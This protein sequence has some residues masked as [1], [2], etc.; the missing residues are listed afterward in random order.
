MPTASPYLTMILALLLLKNRFTLYNTNASLPCITP[1]TEIIGRIWISLR[2]H[3]R[4]SS[5]QLLE[6]CN[7]HMSIN[8]RQGAAS[9][10]L[11]D[12]LQQLP[13]QEFFAAAD[14]RFVAADGSTV[15]RLAGVK[16]AGAFLSTIERTAESRKLVDASLATIAARG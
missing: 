10:F 5:S 1:A 2:K 14:V 4:L 3:F 7:L 15:L 13:G 9:E 6:L 8:H 12:T 11:V 16:D